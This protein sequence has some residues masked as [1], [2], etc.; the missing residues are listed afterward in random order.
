VTSV[1]LTVLYVPVQFTVGDDFS[2]QLN[3][4]TP[5][6]IL[7]RLIVANSPTM[8]S[9]SLRSQDFRVGSNGIEIELLLA[10]AQN[11]TYLYEVRLTVEYTF[12][13]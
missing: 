12:L 8:L 9:G 7:M 11:V 6:I 10:G 13:G 3:G 5:N 2:V 1:R 4:A